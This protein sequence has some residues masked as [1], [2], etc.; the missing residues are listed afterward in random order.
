MFPRSYALNL[1]LTNYFTSRISGAGGS[2]TF[3]TPLPYAS[4]QLT[5]FVVDERL[6]IASNNT[7]AWLIVTSV[8]ET[9][10]YMEYEADVMAGNIGTFVPRTTVISYGLPGE[11]Y[12][13]HHTT[14]DGQPMVDVS[15]HEGT[16]WIERDIT[17]I[18]RLGWLGG[19]PLESPEASWLGPLGPGSLRHFPNYE[20][21]EYGLAIGPNY[22]GGPWQVFSDIRHQS[23][24][25]SFVWATANRETGGVDADAAGS[26]L[27]WWI[28]KKS[29]PFFWLSADGTAGVAPSLLD[30]TAPGPDARRFGNLFT[31]VDGALL[32]GP[33]TTR[34]SSVWTSTRGHTAALSGAYRLEP[35]PFPDTQALAVLPAE[36]NFIENPIF[37]SN[38]TDYWSIPFLDGAVAHS[39]VRPRRGSYC[40]KATAGTG[41]SP[42]LGKGG[43]LSAS[44]PSKDDY[45]TLSAD[46]RTDDE[47]ILAGYCTEEWSVQ[48]ALVVK[49]IGGAEN[50]Q[51]TSWFTVTSEWQ[52]V[53]L[54]HKITQTGLTSVSVY[55]VAMVESAGDYIYID[56]VNLTKTDHLLPHIDGTL[57]GCAWDGAAHNS[58]SAV[59]VATVFNLDDDVG[60]I[61]YKE[62]MTITMWTQVPCDS[63]L[64]EA[65]MIFMDAQST[66]S[67]MDRFKLYFSGSGNCWKIYCQGSERLFVETETEDTYKDKFRIGEQLFLALT[68]DFAENVFVLYVNGL[69]VAGRQ[70][71]GI[72]VFEFDK[73]RVAGDYNGANQPGLIVGEVGVFHRALTS[74]EVLDLY[75][76]SQALVDAG[77][78]A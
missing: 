41:C 65:D 50:Y 47:S 71:G 16:P 29:A 21:T 20:S 51:A 43:A 38:V 30:A 11:G 31:E 3:R 61:N 76:K 23:Y 10:E 9:A 28:G 67:G 24:R 25:A 70:K 27:A 4:P 44:P 72:Q 14:D 56:G 78:F 45:V 49:E 5:R 55:I 74:E 53:A 68:F 1:F 69:K 52:R 15:R 8:T 34:T 54:V 33:H 63:S 46:I 18:L 22:S 26:E 48:V 59:S 17:N 73:W 75:S 57:D 62:N 6:Y 36:T 66:A 58:P 19:L 42:N 40:C 37:G 13:H 2:V 39:S 77:A 12:I 35:G 60:V 32:L 64:G 7:R